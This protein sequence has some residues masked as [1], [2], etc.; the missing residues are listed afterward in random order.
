MPKSFRETSQLGTAEGE[1]DQLYG[2]H[3]KD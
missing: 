1:K 3:S 2:Q